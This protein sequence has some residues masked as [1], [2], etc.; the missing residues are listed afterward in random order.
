MLLISLVKY[1]MTQC[2]LIGLLKARPNTKMEITE[3]K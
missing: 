3:R 2:N 1:N